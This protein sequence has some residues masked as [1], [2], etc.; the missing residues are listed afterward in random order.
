MIYEQI[1]PPD[2]LKNY[3]RYFWRLESLPTDTEP[4]TFKTIV[5]GSPGLMLQHA[6]NGTLYQFDKQLPDIFLYGQS[7]L[8]T[9]ISST[10]AF[11]TIGVYFYPNALKSIFGLDAHELTDSC[12]DLRFLTKKEAIFLSDNV[13]PVSST[14]DQIDWLSAYLWRLIEQNKT[15]QDTIMGYALAQIAHSKGTISLKELQE[16]LNVTERSFERKFRQW[17]GL[18]PKL[19]ARICRFQASLDQMRNNDYEKLS[20]IAFDNGYADHSHFIRTFKEFAGFS[21][22]QFRKQSNEVAENFPEL[23]K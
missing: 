11:R 15:Q 14:A 23:I 16:K 21:P 5:D 6:G 19:Y 3:V 22:D 20:D 18:S 10:D 8:P 4:K 17:V 7:T 9:E 13:L 12:V 1:P 2:Y